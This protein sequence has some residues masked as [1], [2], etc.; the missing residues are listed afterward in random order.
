MTGD[1]HSHCM[2]LVSLGKGI[3]NSACTKIVSG[4][5]LMEDFIA[6]LSD[7]EH[8][9]VNKRE[10]PGNAVFCFRMCNNSKI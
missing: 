7:K 5:A 10:T 9:E 4:V 1:S 6:N 3:L 8:K 2:L